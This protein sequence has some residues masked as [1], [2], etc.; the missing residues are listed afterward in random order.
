MAASSIPLDDGNST[1]DDEVGS[2]FEE[3]PVPIEDVAKSTAALEVK[4]GSE[5]GQF[6]NKP[7]LEEFDVDAEWDCDCTA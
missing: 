1:Q 6:I 2:T 7:G 4:S 3:L 5:L